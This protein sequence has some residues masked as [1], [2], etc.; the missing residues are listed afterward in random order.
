MYVR[1]SVAD[2]AR[3]GPREEERRAQS[4]VGDP[5]SMRAGDALDELVQSEASEV[6]GHPAGGDVAGLEAQQSSEVFA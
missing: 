5:V 1:E 3:I 2:Y 4:E 6:V